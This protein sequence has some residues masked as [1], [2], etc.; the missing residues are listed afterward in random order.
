MEIQFSFIDLLV[1]IVLIWAIYKGIKRGPVVHSLSLLIVLGGIALFGLM[2]VSIA[3]FIRDRA[4]VNLENLHLIIFSILFSATIWLSNL[5]ADK[6][7]ASGTNTKGFA[8]VSL[9]ILT[10][11]I[12][13]VFLLS[14]FFLFLAKFDRSYDFIGSAEK[15][16]T[17]LYRPIK[18]IAP[19]TIKTVSFLKD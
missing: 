12:K 11:I 9:G 16:R 10:N 8:N 19:S 15:N 6:I 14:I 3:D 2:S 18:N 4:T 13:Y 17:K 7:E 5:V 1:I